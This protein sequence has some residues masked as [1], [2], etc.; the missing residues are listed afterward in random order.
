[1]ARRG[2]GLWV[3]LAIPASLALVTLVLLLPSS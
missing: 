1:M 3:L 2:S